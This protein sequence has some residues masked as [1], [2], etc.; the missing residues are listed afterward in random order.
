MKFTIIVQ[1]KTVEFRKPVRNNKHW[2]LFL[3]I[4]RTIK[5]KKYIFITQLKKTIQIK[6]CAI[7]VLIF[8]VNPIS[9]QISIEKENP[10]DPTTW[11]L[12]SSTILSRIENYEGKMVIELHFNN[13]NLYR[14]T[15]TC[16]NKECPRHKPNRKD[17]WLFPTTPEHFS[18]HDVNNDF[19]KFYD[20]I[21]EGF[22]T[23]SSGSTRLTVPEGLVLL[24][25]KKN[26]YGTKVRIEFKDYDI[27]GMNK[28][29]G[30]HYSEWLTKN[31]INYLFSK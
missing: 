8:F 6:Y 14:F 31:Q 1:L 12:P 10:T 28:Y 5:M 3:K 19:E 17:E 13:P 22:L 27:T 30:H 16:V 18:F 24:T 23:S 9:S 26:Q 21:L 7:L 29:M 2:R 15:F 20:I 25:Y 4:Y 11:R